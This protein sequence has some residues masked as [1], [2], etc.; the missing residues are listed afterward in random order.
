MQ[1]LCSRIP[2]MRSIGAETGKFP[3][4][5]GSAFLSEHDFSVQSFV[6]D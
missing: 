3:A 6:P 4:D 2:Q 5:A 1:Q